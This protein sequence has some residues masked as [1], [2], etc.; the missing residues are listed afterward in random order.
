MDVRIEVAAAG[1]IWWLEDPRAGVTRHDMVI[2]ERGGWVEMGF[3]AR[4]GQ[5]MQCFEVTLARVP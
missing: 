4:T 3:I 2:D 1:Y 5:E